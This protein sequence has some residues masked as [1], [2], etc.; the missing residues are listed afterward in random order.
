MA[1]A[2]KV[3]CFTGILYPDEDMSH[4]FVL[5]KLKCGYS[6]CAIDHDKDVYSSVDDCPVEDYGK[7][8]KKHTH[9]FI[10]LKNPRYLVPLC[11]ELG[12]RPT[13]LRECR[14]SKSALLYMIHDGYPDKYQYNIEDVY[15]PLR[16]ELGKLL[17]SESESSRILKIL[18]L[19]DSM[20][21]PCSYRQLLVAVCENDMYGDFRRM[22]SGVC[23]LLDDHNGNIF[24]QF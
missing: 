3:R 6:F 17:V 4:L 10:R 11:E 23:R 22:G 16:H 21:V 7:L 1:T 18:D 12:L 8:K 2:E 20:P 13:Y 14:D 9:I 15:G 24:G 5:N 19:L